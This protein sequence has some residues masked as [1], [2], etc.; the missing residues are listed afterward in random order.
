VSALDLT[1]PAFAAPLEVPLDLG[2]LQITVRPANVGQIARMVSVAAPAVDALM[3]LPPSLVQAL[4]HGELSADHIAELFELLAKHP[5]KLAELVATACG[6]KLD[7]VQALLPD[8][9]AYLFAVVVAVN[10]DFFSRATGAL[11]AAGRVLGQ[12]QA[13]SGPT[14]GP[15]PLTA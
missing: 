15:A 11:Q 4:Q 6:L 2:T 7:E 8:R 10:A 14:P 12:L 5:N 3:A 1:V 9:F 13:A